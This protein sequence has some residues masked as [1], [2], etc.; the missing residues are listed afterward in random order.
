IGVA[1]TLWQQQQFKACLSL[2]YRGALTQLIHKEKIL[3]SKSH[4]EGDILKLS[5]SSLAPL[6]Q[7]YLQQLTQAWQLIA[8]AH[9]QPSDQLM[10][11]L[12][13]HWMTDFAT[14]ESRS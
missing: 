3:L 14:T 13:N 9:H 11:H 7:D 5:Q 8:Y 12:F 10:N 2:L 6:Q 1:Q 4:T